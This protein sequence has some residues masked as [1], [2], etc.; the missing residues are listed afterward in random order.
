MMNK[1]MVLVKHISETN[2]VKIGRKRDGYTEVHHPYNFD[3]SCYLVED[4]VTILSVQHLRL[5]I[6][7]FVL[8]L[9]M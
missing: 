6:L 9:I 3:Y 7:S 1:A 5:Y 4:E 2:E 8:K